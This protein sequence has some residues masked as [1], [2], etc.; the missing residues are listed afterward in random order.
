MGQNTCR[1]QGDEHPEAAILR[2]ERGQ[3]LDP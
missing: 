2:C 1:I 3:G